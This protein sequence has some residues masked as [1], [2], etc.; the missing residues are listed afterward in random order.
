MIRWCA[1]RLVLAAVCV[2]SAQDT[3][4]ATV[5]SLTIEEVLSLSKAGVA[6]EV[7][8]A[9]VKRNA[10]AFDLNSDEIQVLKNNGVSDT[11]I[12]YLTDPSQP[13]SLPPPPAPAPAPRSPSK[14][15]SDPL[16]LKVPAEVG[17]YYWAGGEEFIPLDLKPVVPLKEPSKM[18]SKLSVG[19]VK[20]HVVGSV[21]GGTAKARV[22]SGAATF[23]A[24]PGEKAAIDDFV[25]LNMEPSEGRRNLDFG[26]KL[27]KPVFPAKSVHQFE[28]KEVMPGLYRLAV[29]PSGSG[30]Y[31]FF[32]LGSG[33][34][35]KGLL[36]KGYDFGRR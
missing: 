1:A 20:G 6:E 24:R 33:D 31:I 26:T 35:K 14:P 23:Y 22:P 4:K 29:P 27:G 19:L 12:K 34:E 15:P 11:V 17:I 13:Y 28:S 32:I 16:A 10:K 7:I 21:I 30:E 5:G 36:G 25:L 8:V 9:R 2:V 18:V 3:P